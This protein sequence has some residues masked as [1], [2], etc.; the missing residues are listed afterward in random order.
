[1]HPKKR[2]E[3]ILSE[4]K[5]DSNVLAFIP[6]GSR[7]KGVIT[8][9]S[10]WDV[11]II[12]K[13][14][15]E[16]QYQKKYPFEKYEKLNF[17]VIGLKNFQNYLKWGSPFRWN[18]YN[19][20]YAKAVFD[21]S[22]KIQKWLDSC[23]FIPRN[24]LKKYI[25]E[26]LGGYTNYVYRSFKNNRDKRF[27]ASRMDAIEA[28]GYFLNAIFAIHGR[29]RPYNK[30]LEWE[31]EKYPLS[32]LNISFSILIKN[33]IKVLDNVDIKSQKIIFAEL[34]KIARK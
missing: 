22:N 27:L 23:R 10:D 16:K 2:Y 19:F 12:V 21:K 25:E 18:R 30:Y 33:I 4:C 14:N 13:D 32:K 5:F 20:V 17:T 29:I 24:F 34:E 1:M 6:T 3:G 11:F 15:F 28:N 31:L 8:P 26:N 9:N 7:A